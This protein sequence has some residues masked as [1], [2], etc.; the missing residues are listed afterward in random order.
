MC[1]AWGGYDFARSPGN[2]F[3]NAEGAEGQWHRKVPIPRATDDDHFTS[4]MACELKIFPY[5]RN[6]GVVVSTVMDKDCQEALRKKQ[7]A[8]LQLVDPHSDAK[9]SCPS[10]WGLLRLQ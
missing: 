8:L 10:G 4:R 2:I 6:I 9:V 7:K 1:W 5:R 3:M